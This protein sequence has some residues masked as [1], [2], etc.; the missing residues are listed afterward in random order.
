MD[1]SSPFFFRLVSFS[2]RMVRDSGREREKSL[3]TNPK[4]E[5]EEKVVQMERAILRL[6]R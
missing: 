5:V 6:W 3:T 1:D 2:E 4:T